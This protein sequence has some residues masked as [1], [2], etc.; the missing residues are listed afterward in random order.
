MMIPVS[1]AIKFCITLKA[2]AQQEEEAQVKDSRG[3]V[4]RGDKAIFSEGEK[5]DG[6]GALGLDWTN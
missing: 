1:R 4:S 3:Q 2:E 5:E 6:H